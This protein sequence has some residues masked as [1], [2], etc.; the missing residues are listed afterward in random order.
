M[1]RCERKVVIDRAFTATKVRAEHKLE[2][3]QNIRDELLSTVFCL[4][5]VFLISNSSKIAVLTKSEFAM[6]SNPRPPPRNI[7][8]LQ[9]KRTAYPFSMFSNFDYLEPFVGATNASNW[10][11]F[12]IDEVEDSGSR[13]E[14]LGYATSLPLK[15]YQVLNAQLVDPDGSRSTDMR[16]HEM[17]RSTWVAEFVTEL[18][19][20][21]PRIHQIENTEARM[22]IASEFDRAVGQGLADPADRTVTISLAEVLSTYWQDNPFIW[23]VVKVAGD[24]NKVVAH[25]IKENSNGRPTMNM[26]CELDAGGSTSS[27]VSPSVASSEQSFYTAPSSVGSASGSP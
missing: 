17:I 10:S 22:A 4:R 20:R 16:L 9:L 12:T 6:S 2:H 26:V 15:T 23:T 18:R 7:A 13:D 25:L 11:F 5:V 8:E 27:S 21:R 14:I 24:R 1:P 19:L 3:W